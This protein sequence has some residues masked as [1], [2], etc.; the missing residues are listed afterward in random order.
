LIIISEQKTVHEQVIGWITLSSANTLNALTLSMVNAMH[1][2]LMLW[3]TRSDVVCVVIVGEGRAFCAGGDVRRMRQGILDADDYCERFFAKEY[4][5]DYAI[6]T[7]PKP[8]LVWG[9]GVVMG[10]GLGLLIGASH[11]VVTPTTRM[12]MPEVNIGLYPD[13][14]M[15]YYLSRLPTG[16]GLFMGITACEWNGADAIVLGFADYLLEDSGLPLLENQLKNADWSV[17]PGDNHACVSQVL[18]SLAAAEQSTQMMCFSEAL[19]QACAPS[20]KAALQHVPQLPIDQPWFSKAVD[21]LEKGCPVS[22]RIIEEQLRRARSL[23]LR[24]V[25]R[26]D[27]IVSIQCMRHQDFPEGVRAQLVDKDKKPHW[28]FTDVTSVPD[29]LINEHFQKP[30][31]WH[32][33]EDWV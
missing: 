30:G 3:E 14:G 26:Q 1:E 18:Q 8:L 5:L 21:T 33:L 32:P 17:L 27:W 23:S 29:T 2:Q 31:E 12:A 20:L 6:H 7:Y 22:M 10:G 15:S 13:V 11:R 24:A 25:F 19:A 28:S 16:L 9:H 4:Q